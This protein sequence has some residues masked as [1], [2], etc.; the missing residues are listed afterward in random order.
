MVRKRLVVKRAFSRCMIECD[1]DFDLSVQEESFSLNGGLASRTGCRDCLT[2]NGVSTITCHKHTRNLCFG[3]S[4]DLLQITHLVHIEPTLENVSVG[5]MANGKEESIDGN[6]YQ[7]FVGPCMRA[8]SVA[9][10]I[11]DSWQPYELYPTRL[12]C[13]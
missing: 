4:I 9:L 13:R 12:L 7:F 3:R 6:I 11:S 2:I 10:V 1:F 8:C 5:L